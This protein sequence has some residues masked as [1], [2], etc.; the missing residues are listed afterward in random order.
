MDIG[1][2]DHMSG[3]YYMYIYYLHVQIIST[4]AYCSST[5]INDEQTRVS[6]FVIALSPDPTSQPLPLPMQRTIAIACMPDQY[7]LCCTIFCLCLLWCFVV[8]VLLSDCK[9]HIFHFYVYRSTV[10][11]GDRI[12]DRTFGYYG[13]C[14]FNKCRPAGSYDLLIIAKSRKIWEFHVEKAETHMNIG[15]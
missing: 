7:R 9:L 14:E 15:I 12:N 6:W 13:P 5:Y 8:L 3:R 4:S 2:L 1:K 10:L 11:L